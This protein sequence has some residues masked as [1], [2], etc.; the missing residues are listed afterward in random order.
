MPLGHAQG[1]AIVELVFAETKRGSVHG[2]DQLVLAAMLFIQKRSRLSGIEIEGCFNGVLGLREVI[3]LLRDVGQKNLVAVGQRCVGVF[4]FLDRLAHLLDYALGF[5]LIIRLRVAQSAHVHMSVHVLVVLMMVSHGLCGRFQFAG[6][7]LAGL[8]RV[9]QRPQ[10]GK[11]EESEEWFHW[12]APS[13]TEYKVP[14][15]TVGRKL[16]AKTRIVASRYWERRRPRLRL[17]LMPRSP[18]PRAAALPTQ[19]GICRYP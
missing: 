5:L 16:P 8:L 18:R 4:V 7:R 14:N 15:P 3:H 13:K 6:R 2:A 9:E 17:R 1:N 10:Q 19:S 11:A 12:R